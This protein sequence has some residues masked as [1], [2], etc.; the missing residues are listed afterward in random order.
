MVKNIHPHLDDDEFELL[1]DRRGNRTWEELLA[2][3]SLE[4]IRKEKQAETEEE[5]E[6]TEEE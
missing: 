1:D 5:V 4:R 2:D 3:R 6:A